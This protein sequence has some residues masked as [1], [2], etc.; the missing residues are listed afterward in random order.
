M[1]TCERLALVRLPEINTPVQGVLNNLHGYWEPPSFVKE[2]WA[3]G[4][5]FCFRD[6]GDYCIKAEDVRESYLEAIKL[7][8]RD[9]A[10]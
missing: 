8:Y 9:N 4:A 7:F 10:L 5:L 2:F 1:S 3:A 6:E